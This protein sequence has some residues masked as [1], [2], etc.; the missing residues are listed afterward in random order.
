MKYSAVVLCVTA[1]LTSAAVSSRHSQ[2]SDD[3]PALEPVVMKLA[4]DLAAMSAEF[5]QVKAEL[6]DVKVKLGECF[7]S[8]SPTNRTGSPQ[9]L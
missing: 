4:S 1:L 6:A 8:S 3:G 2:R 5:A 9:G 7:K